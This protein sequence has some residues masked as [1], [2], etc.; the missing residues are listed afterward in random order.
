[1]ASHFSL[2]TETLSLALLFDVERCL[3]ISRVRVLSYFGIL[4]KEVKFRNKKYQKQ[5]GIVR[6]IAT[7]RLSCEFHR[8]S[9]REHLE[10][11]RRLPPMFRHKGCVER[12]CQELFLWKGGSSHSLNSPPGWNLLKRQPG[13]P[14]SLSSTIGNASLISLASMRCGGVPADKTPQQSL[15]TS[16]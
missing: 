4:P 16:P 7:D 11:T 10:T 15:L 6:G 9:T 5:I 2:L 12:R 14:R 3:G 13:H 1:M 8:C